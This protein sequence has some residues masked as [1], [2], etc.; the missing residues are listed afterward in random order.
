MPFNFVRGNGGYPRVEFSFKPP[1]NGGIKPPPPPVPKGGGGLKLLGKAKG[2]FALLGVQVFLEILLRQDPIV[3]GEKELEALERWNREVGQ[4]E[5]VSE[6]ELPLWYGGQDPNTAYN[7]RYGRAGFSNGQFVGWTEFLAPQPQGI[8]PPI[9]DVR[10]LI[11]G[12]DFGVYYFWMFRSWANY[13]RNIPPYTKS[14]PF[15]I[16]VKDASG[17][18]KRWLYSTSRGHKVIGFEPVG[19]QPDPGG[20]PPAKGSIVTKSNYPNIQV[21]DI[22][23][24]P[25]FSLPDGKYGFKPI[26]KT[27]KIISDATKTNNPDSTDNGSVPNPIPF[28][29]V[30]G[31]QT[32]EPDTNTGSIPDEQPETEERQLEDN[33][34]WIEIDGKRYIKRTTRDVLDGD[35]QIDGKTR[36]ITKFPEPDGNPK[37]NSKIDNKVKKI[38]RDGE[39]EI[40]LERYTGA[41]IT[42]P[43]PVIVDSKKTKD[44]DP[45]P[46]YE[47]PFIPP[48]PPIQTKPD[49]CKGSCAYKAA[50][51]GTNLLDGNGNT[52]SAANLFNDVVFQNDLLKKIDTTTTFTKNFVNKAW[53]ATGA[54]K[55]MNTISAVASLHNAAMLS[56]NAA[57]SIGDV[58]TNALSLLNIKGFDG[59]PIDVNSAVG[60][61]IKN[62]LAAVFGEANLNAASAAWLRLN[63]IHQAIS[64]TVYA[65]QGT[66]NALLEADEITGGHVAKIGNALQEQGII[67]DDTYDWMNPE[68]DYQQPFNGILGKINAIEEMGDRVSSVVS[69]GLE[70]KEN[71]TELVTSSQ[72]LIDATAD[73]VTTK[74]NAEDT[75]KAESESPIIDRLDTLKYEPAENE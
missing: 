55:I 9:V 14:G 22:T 13:S 21:S 66:K 12:E 19:G 54:D 42:L 17:E 41:P 27:D 50:N 7:Y 1:P 35:T 62:K 23:K 72:Q 2:G 63:R 31:K 39:V 40:E 36:I 11:G 4:Q 15:E 70:I 61:L 68:P 48:P 46:D 56:Q 53:R 33:E 24:L 52:I 74:N 5:T 49:K 45:K 30:K 57:Q 51:R 10:L 58:A 6:G 75:A 47:P 59:E 32:I 18:W 71:T 44:D 60:G 25:D 38:T 67:E 28:P 37:P 20:D 8:I 26:T 34:E 73:F 29:K 65:I 3:S 43:P 64:S 16:E 69:T